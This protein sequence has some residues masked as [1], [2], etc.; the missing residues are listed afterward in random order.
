MLL[1][2][3]LNREETTTVPPLEVHEDVFTMGTKVMWFELRHP[4]SPF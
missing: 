4:I 3:R 2:K 1:D